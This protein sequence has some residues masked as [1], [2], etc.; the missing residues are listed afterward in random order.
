MLQFILKQRWC[1]KRGLKEAPPPIGSRY[2]QWGEDICWALQLTALSLTLDLGS[3]S[4]FLSVPN[5][6]LSALWTFELWLFLFPVWVWLRNQ[7]ET[8]QDS[9]E[10]FQGQ[11]PP[12]PQLHIWRTYK[13][14]E[15]DPSQYKP[16]LWCWLAWGWKNCETM[17]IMSK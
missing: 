17:Y 6:T 1:Q 15:T 12:C 4:Q 5:S 2:W 10:P 11:A 16:T 8:T 7:T 13:A 9:A 3:P 14:K